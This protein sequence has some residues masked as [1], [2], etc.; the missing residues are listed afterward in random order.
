MLLLVSAELAIAVRSLFEGCDVTLI[1]LSIFQRVA[2][3]SM[4]AAAASRELCFF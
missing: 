4:A 3:T 2:A 1:N